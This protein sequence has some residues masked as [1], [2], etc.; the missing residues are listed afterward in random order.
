MPPIGTVLQKRDRNGNLRC[1]CEIV[2]GG[3]RY[4]GTV[5]RSLSSAAIAAAADLGLASRAAN[6]WAFWGLSKTTRP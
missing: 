2:E 1:E 6:G 4:G 3:V 5:Y